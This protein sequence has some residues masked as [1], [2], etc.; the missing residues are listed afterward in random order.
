MSHRA[1]VRAADADTD[2]RGALKL[3]ASAAHRKDVATLSRDNAI[4][5]AAQ[6]GASAAEIAQATGLQETVVERIIDRPSS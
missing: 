3:A 1:P 5:F 4:R 6:S 2:K